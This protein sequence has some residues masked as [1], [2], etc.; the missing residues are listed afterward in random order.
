MGASSFISS[1]LGV[2]FDLGW[3]VGGGGG[4]KTTAGFG[5]TGTCV[6]GTGKTTTGGGVK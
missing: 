4:G 6:G 5:A 2:F 3:I 1:R